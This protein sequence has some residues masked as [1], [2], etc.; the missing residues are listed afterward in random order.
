MEGTSVKDVSPH[1][2][3][4]GFFFLSALSSFS[5]SAILKA[6]AAIVLAVGGMTIDVRSSDIKIWIL[7]FFSDID[8]G[9]Y[10]RVFLV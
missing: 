1:T 6:K 2:Y 7:S 8:S 3:F 5:N 9:V 10:F 4:L